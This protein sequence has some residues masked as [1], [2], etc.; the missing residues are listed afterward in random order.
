LLA[1]P[2]F[3]QCGE[4]RRS[5]VYYCQGPKALH[6]ESDTAFVNLLDDTLPKENLPVS[7][8]GGYLNF[9]VWSKINL[10]FEPKEIKLYQKR[11]PVENKTKIMQHV[12]KMQ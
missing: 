6:S 1:S 9:N 4:F 10:L 11:H 5:Y 8:R 12:L 7:C 3:S 2:F